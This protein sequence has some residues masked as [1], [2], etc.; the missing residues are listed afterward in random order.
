VVS[1]LFWLT[2]YAVELDEVVDYGP[3]GPQDL[4]WIVAYSEPCQI[5]TLVWTIVE[6]TREEYDSFKATTNPYPTTESGSCP[7]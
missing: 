1:A 2:A 6:L 7:F 4:A 5:F 3:V